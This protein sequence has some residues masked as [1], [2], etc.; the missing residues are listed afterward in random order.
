[1]TSRITRSQSLK[2]TD[3]SQTDY[4]MAIE[5][6]SSHESAQNAIVESKMMN[7]NEMQKYF[8]SKFYQLFQDMATKSCF[9]KLLKVIQ[10]QRNRIEELE[11]KV[12]VMD[13]LIT[14]LKNH[15][16]DQEQ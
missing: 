16:D 7:V 10:V 2:Q 15:V 1:M 9:G 6:L 3:D 11:S 13:S 14:Q 8:D 4:Q 12:S 5:K